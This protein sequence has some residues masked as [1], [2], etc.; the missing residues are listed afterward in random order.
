MQ[1]I[2][3]KLKAKERSAFTLI[4]VIFVIIVIGVLVALATSDLANTLFNTRV[5]ACESDIKTMGEAVMKY[6]AETGRIP[7][8]ADID[9]L[10]EELTR[11]DFEIEGRKYGPWMTENMNTKDPWG[12]DFIWKHEG[13]SKYDICSNGD[14]DK[15]QEICYRT[16]GRHKDS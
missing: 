15:P 1:K 13:G 4:E 11:D 3:S 10:K 5:T 16:L 9:E 14:P 8:V 7:D 12:N 2:I 6:Y